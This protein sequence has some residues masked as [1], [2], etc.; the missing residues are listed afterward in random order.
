MPLNPSTSDSPVLY[1]VTCDATLRI[2]I[3][4]LDSPQFLQLH[5]T[6]DLSSSVPSLPPSRKRNNNSPDVFSLSREVLRGVLSTILADSS[7]ADD[8]KLRRLQEIC[9]GE[10]DMFL[11][12]FPDRSL[13][14]RAVTA[15]TLPVILPSCV[16]SHFR[17]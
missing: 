4:V 15:S 12:V 11:Q 1:T 9:D 3:P 16:S 5:A 14:I 8:P 7:D 2:F 10:W 6:L 13:T 17:V